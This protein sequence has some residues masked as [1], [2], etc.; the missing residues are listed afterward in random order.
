MSSWRASGASR[1]R[2]VV[3]TEQDLVEARTNAPYLT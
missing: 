3:S 1:S 2:L